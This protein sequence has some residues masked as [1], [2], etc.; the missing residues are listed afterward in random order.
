M[1]IDDSLADI[2]QKG[3]VSYE[4]ISDDLKLFKKQLRDAR[5]SLG[6]LNQAVA[7][8]RIIDNMQ[9]MLQQCVIR[10]FGVRKKVKKNNKSYYKF[11]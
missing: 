7:T 1:A 6:Y 11:K 8:E 4:E 10:P 5:V 3:I 2:L 9:K